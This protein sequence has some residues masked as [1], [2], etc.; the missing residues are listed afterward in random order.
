LF[1]AYWRRL[2][3][4]WL[5]VVFPCTLAAQQYL[6]VFHAGSQATVYNPTTLEAL[7]SPVVGSGAIRAIGVPDQS[8]P[9]TFSKI[10]ILRSDSVVVLEPKPPFTARTSFDLRAPISLGA[11]SA[12][13]TQDSK[14]L[15]VA[16]GRFVHVF[17]ATDPANPQP[18][19][20][21]L[22]DE[23]TGL[24]ALPS[25][26]RAYVTVL[27]SDRVEIISLNSNPP[28]RLAG[29][30]ALPQIPTAIAAAP[31]ASALYAAATGSFFEIDPIAN[32]L[33]KEIDGSSG[34]PLTVGFDPQAPV[35]SA[36]VRHGTK[37]T[38]FDLL[39]RTRSVEFTGVSALTEAIS[40]GDDL[41]YF[42]TAVTGQIY[43]GNLSSGSFAQLLN[44][45][46]QAPFDRPGVDIEVDP[47]NQDVFLALGG[48]GSGRVVHLNAQATILRNQV[49]PLDLPTAL[50]AIASPGSSAAGIEVY[51]GNNQLATVGK[52]L[53][54]PLV[55]RVIDSSLRPAANQTVQFSTATP[56]VVFRPANP[57]TNHAGIA[58]TLVTVPITDPFTI[59]ARI[60]PV[61]LGA[62]FDVNTALAEEEGLSIVSGDYQLTAGGSDFPRPFQV[63]ALTS[64]GP[65]PNLSISIMPSN[66]AGNC[67]SVAM[68][69]AD[70]QASFICGTTAVV[71]P[72]ET[73]I[74]VTD[75]FGRTL[76]EPF[77][78]TTV[79]NPDKLPQDGRLISSAPL[80]AQVNTTVEDGIAIRVAERVAGVPVPNLG[81]EFT[82]PGDVRVD[83]PI[84][85]TDAEGIAR[86]N[87][88]FGCKIE[89]NQI[90]ATLNSPGLPKVAISHSSV[91]GPATR[92]LRLQGNNQ[93]GVSG[94]VL[95]LALLTR[96][97]DE[98]GNVVASAPLIWEVLPPAAATLETAFTQTNPN[99]EASAR[100]R[101]GTR[102]GPFAVR[103]SSGAAT[104]DFNLAATA[105]ANRVVAVSGDNQSVPA[106]Q[107]APQPLVVELQ[108][109]GGNPLANTQ[110]D[111]RITQGSGG[112]AGA[113]AVTDESGRASTLVTAGPQVGPLQVEARAGDGVFVFTL[114]VI[115]RTP[116]VPTAGFVN[117]ASFVS[118]WTPGST[119][120]IF[121]VGLM[122]GVDGVVLP[123]APFPTTLRG[124]QVLVENTP[125]P[126]LS[127][128]NINGQEQINIQVPFGVPAPGEAL[129]TIINNGASATFPGVPTFAAQPAVFEVTL[130]GGRIAATLHADFS[131]VDPDHPARPGEVLQLFWTGG[132]ATNPAVPTDHPGP[133]P[134]AEV[135]AAVTV[136]VNGTNADVLGS[137]YA[138]TLV[139][140]YQTNFRVPAGASGT[141]L[142]VQLAVNSA[143]SQK[144]TIPFAP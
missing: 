61:D 86:A 48:D 91:R 85:V 75:S 120:T 76:P 25:A 10:Y 130:P 45:N 138:P 82:V 30:I 56:N 129:V 104:V 51:G 58:Q 127:M 99:G 80:V 81:I 96:A 107:D 59:D 98:C 12:L 9:S 52:V 125:A 108:D 132:G 84:A 53:P 116:L 68:T 83:P 46:T 90:T 33:T 2:I 20:I 143:Q 128:A 94:Q 63:R 28:V 144:V 8:A 11:R 93:S 89:T 38:A 74:Q 117:G 37:V 118:G 27:D 77:H 34:S 16:G 114:T 24:T 15:V 22:G 131:L 95:P 7:A 66:F 13:L 50:S 64:G 135:V 54:K 115:G 67:P 19:T 65:I 60:L 73:R 17:D 122:E 55:V 57:L 142:I 47:S 121:G 18:V 26:E 69:G 23:I 109:A 42:F 126:I 97:T 35:R 43:L 140:V 92:M 123:P 124:V 79:Q 139:T 31:N 101:I 136:S 78:V 44:P 111:F 141:S 106:G 3:L 6:F 36:F 133:V 32:T 102:P 137:F 119:G 134:P 62:T 41:V 72:V 112:L 105:T 39:R 87:V 113:S 88:T 100:V 21:D 71:S 110:V 5:F 49:V 1:A 29:P 4:A 103:V 14:R 70:G 40:P